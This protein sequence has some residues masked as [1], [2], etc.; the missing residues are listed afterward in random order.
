MFG[1]I[2]AYIPEEINSF[3]RRF[4]QGCTSLYKCLCCCHRFTIR[5]L[6]KYGYC[7]T[8]LQSHSFVEANSEMFELKKRTKAT[9]P[10]LYMEG[11]FF[12]TICKTLILMFSLIVVYFLLIQQDEE[13]YFHNMLNLIV[14][15]LVR[16]YVYFR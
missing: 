10:E 14:P 3:L 16:F 2:N 8:I 5:K 7:E 9:L 1:S 6:S 11:N 15:L 13:F 12:T 4:E